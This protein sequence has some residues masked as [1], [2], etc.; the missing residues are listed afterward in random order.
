MHHHEAVLGL[1]AK[2][3]TQ[4]TEAL[5]IVINNRGLGVAEEDVMRVAEARNIVIERRL[6]FQRSFA[7]SI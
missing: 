1:L 7:D 2:A 3:E 6:W 5:E 4:L